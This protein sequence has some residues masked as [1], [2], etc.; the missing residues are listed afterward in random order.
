MTTLFAFPL[1]YEDPL[2]VFAQFKNAPYSLFF[3]SADLTHPL[4]RY[5]FI[6]CT[7]QETIEASGTD[8]LI[9]RGKEQIR[10]KGNPFNAVKERL[11]QFPAPTA[12][13]DL[14]PFQGGAAG[15]FGY[16]L[17]RT[18]ENLPTQS[19]ANPNLPDMCVGLYDRVIGYDHERR[20]AWIMALAESEDVAR[21]NCQPFISKLKV[22]RL[23][24]APLP[25]YE[26]DWRAS[27]T[28]EAYEK[29]VAHVIE[30][31]H[32]G[33]IFQANLSQKFEADLPP[34]FDSFSHYCQLR[35]INPAPFSA[36]MDFGA[37]KLSSSS[38]ERFLYVREGAVETRPIKGTRR[39]LPH[40][41]QEAAIRHELLNS[42]KDRAEN[43][44][45]VD[46]LRNDLSRV[47]DDFSV[48]VPRLFNLESFAAVHHLVSIVTGRLRPKKE[49]PDL[50][51]ACFPGGSIT[52]APKIRAMQI[53][54]ELEPQRRGPY[55]GA[56]GYI[57]FNRTM[58]TSIIIR[59]LVYEGNKVSFCVGGGIVADSN[60]AAEY[61]ETMDKA[62]AL[63]RSFAATPEKVR[64]SA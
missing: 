42:E 58:D 46:L 54:E 31:I 18:L 6:A 15:F 8:I 13:D 40:P 39:R 14:P 16:D 37:L 9:T 26:P 22:P 27:F 38:P 52:G 55:C 23:L 19:R 10:R 36:Y 24:P 57:G 30:Y 34:D 60:P 53:I 43:A 3:D 12:R 51:Q 59:T 56:M 2:A 25:N 4:S 45:I 63:F 50:L 21:R 7:P 29:A 47:C 49:A 28:R 41:Q 62:D 64:K 20:Q 33:D 17:A 35:E 61:Q 11:S 48:E 32:A 5:S 44:M 1:E